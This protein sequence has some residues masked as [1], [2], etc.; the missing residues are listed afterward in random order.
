MMSKTKNIFKCFSKS[1]LICTGL[2]CLVVLVCFINK[3][4]IQQ[5][6]SEYSAEK[7]FNLARKH[8]TGIGAEKDLNKAFALHAQAAAL[9]IYF[10][11]VKPPDYF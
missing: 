1:I 4:S 3:D 6:L 9:N 5:N 10:D 11:E 2:F 7:I 8:E